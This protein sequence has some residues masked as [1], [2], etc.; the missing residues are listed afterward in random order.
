MNC[1]IIKY[2]ENK[3]IKI[4]KKI[5]YNFNV[6]DNI[7][8]YYKNIQKS[9]ETFKKKIKNKDQLFTGYVISI[10]GNNKFS[11]TFTVRRIINNI[12]VEIIFFLFSPYIS[13]IIINKKGKV[14]KSKLYYIRKLL[15]KKIKIKE[16]KNRDI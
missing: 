11:K 1:N 9:K 3:Y 10:K 4:N 14:K 8:V 12:G 13:N 15:N 5:N 16:N 7:N 2:L 6:G